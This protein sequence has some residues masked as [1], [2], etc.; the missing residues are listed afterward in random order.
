MTAATIMWIG[1]FIIALRVHLRAPRRLRFITLRRRPLLRM[2]TEGRI[3]WITMGRAASILRSATAAAMVMAMA[4]GEGMADTMAEATGIHSASAVL[5][6]GDRYPLRVK[7]WEKNLQT[8]PNV[9]NFRVS[10]K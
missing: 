5:V 6:S 3:M 7:L 8:L 9:E 2:D 4:M 10:P 1:P